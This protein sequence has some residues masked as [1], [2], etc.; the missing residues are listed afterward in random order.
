M[1]DDS[2]DDDHEIPFVLGIETDNDG[3]DASVN[4]ASVNDASAN[5][6]SANDSDT[7]AED[8]IADAN[9]D[10][11]GDVQIFTINELLKLG[12]QM[13]WY[14]SKRIRRAKRETTWIDSESTLVV[15][16]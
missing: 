1:S 8:D 6:A 9:D 5:N 11:T 13:V 12:L 3:R 16:H 2:S 10:D 4:D 7:I 15:V 14:W